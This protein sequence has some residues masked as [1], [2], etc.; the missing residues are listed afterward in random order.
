MILGEKRPD[1]PET[2]YNFVY[3]RSF[4]IYTDVIEYIIAGDTKS[5]PCCV[6]IPLFLSWKQL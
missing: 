2:T 6:T 1:T 3:T 4:I 5:V